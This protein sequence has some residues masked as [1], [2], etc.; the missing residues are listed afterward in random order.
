MDTTTGN[1]T[2][3]GVLGSTTPGGLTQLPFLALEISVGPSGVPWIWEEPVS[4]TVA[5]ETYLLEVQNVEIMFSALYTDTTPMPLGTY[6]ATLSVKS[7]DPVAETPKVTAVMHIIP[8]YVTP[9]ATFTTTAPTCLGEATTFVNLSEPGVPPTA[10]YVWDMG[11]GTVMTY[12]GDVQP[13]FDYT[14]AAAGLYD[15]TLQACNLQGYE[16]V[17]SSYTETVEILPLA[18][19]D[20]TYVVTG[21][22]V[23]FTNTSVDADTYLWDF[24]DGVTDTVAS[25]THVYAAA[26]S[27][28]VTLWAFNE[29]G[30]D[31]IEMVI[32]VAE[33]DLALT[34][35]A[36]ASV[37]FGDTFTYTLT[38]ENLGTDDATNV[39]LVDTLP[40]S[41][42]FVSAT[43]PCTQAGG[44]VTC[45][46]GTLANGATAVVEIVVTAPS[47][48]GTITNDATVTADEFDP[49]LANNDASAD[50]LVE[51]DIFFYFLPILNKNVLFP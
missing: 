6:T 37:F 31:M 47:V 30:M 2:L 23:A 32:E 22:S 26:G 27:Y 51:Q 46:L 3:V 1:T 33:A 8:E 14:Y 34:K 16:Y 43:A 25:P 41:V 29:C 35:D 39:V 49:D 5:G 36:P 38:V 7:N 40:A 10:Y 44:V 11:D 12:T 20:F 13:A 42:T 17:C 4:G 48:A 15:V 21:L 50:T 19:A 9:T 28:T 24:G 18:V 45:N